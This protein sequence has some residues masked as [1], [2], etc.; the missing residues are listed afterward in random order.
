MAE[1]KV[2]QKLWLQ[3]SVRYLLSREVTVTKVGRKW[4]YIDNERY[5]IDKETLD[6]DGDGYCSPGKCYHSK[7]EYEALLAL[8]DRWRGLSKKMDCMPLDMT[9]EKINQIEQ[10]L[11]AS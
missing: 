2:G 4:A 11:G 10:L 7:D 6:I 3:S 5:R 9:F 1:L 8:Y